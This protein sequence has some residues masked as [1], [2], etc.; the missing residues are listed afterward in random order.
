[1]QLVRVVGAVD[2]GTEPGAVG[3]TEDLA[4]LL[5][6]RDTGLR[7][8]GAVAL[9]EGVR[10]GEGVDG[11]AEVLVGDEVEVLQVVGVLR[12][13]R[14]TGRLLGDAGQ[15]APGVAVDVGA[16]AVRNVQDAAIDTGLVETVSD[17]VPSELAHQLLLR[18]RV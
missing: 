18:S 14:R 15:A 17:L 11:A 10:V 12:G 3:Q 4:V 13:R 2:V 16:E 9:G 6:D 5:T 1:M 8:G 7:R